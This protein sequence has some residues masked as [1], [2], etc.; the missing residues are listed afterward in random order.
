MGLAKSSY[1]YSPA[2]ADP[3]D[4]RAE[5]DLLDRIESI[6][7]ESSRY[8]YR[9]VTRQLHKDG[10]VVNHKK[11][12]RLMRESDL[13]CQLKRR[14]VK[15][16]DSGHGFSIYP[17]LLKG[18]TVTDLNKVWLSDITYIRIK[19]GFVYLAVVL[20]AYSRKAIGYCI[21]NTL[22]AAL[23]LKALSM[24]IQARKPGVGVIHHSDQGVQYASHEYTDELKKH[25]FKISMSRKGNPYD[26]AMME[27]F[28]KTLKYEEVNLCEYETM[29][30]VEAGVSHFIEWVY[31]L[32]RLH[33]SI[34]YRSPDE[35]EELLLKEHTLRI[36]A[37]VS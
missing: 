22:D 6:C 11:V 8:G 29:A 2:P 12:L 37:G 3:V 33:S 5:T 9:R 31:N 32:K 25:G 20:D 13:L 23:T 10:L 36:P 14:W 18:R 16:T 24:A 15:T 1:Y 19:R 21:S 7:L 27:S 34:E 30:D 35:Y 17:N 26:N 4:V 28:F